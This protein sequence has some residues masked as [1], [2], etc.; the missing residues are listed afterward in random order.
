MSGERRNVAER[1]GAKELD[2]GPRSIAISPPLG[3]DIQSSLVSV[4]ESVLPLFLLLL[5][6]LLSPK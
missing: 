2:Y 6:L 3:L 5:L 1:M 4:T